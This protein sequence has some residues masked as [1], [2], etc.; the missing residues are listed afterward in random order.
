VFEEGMQAVVRV[1]DFS[2]IFDAYAKF[3]ESVVEAQMERQDASS[4]DRDAALELDLRL[5][6]LEHLMDRRPFLVNDVHLRQNPH[7]VVEWIKRV[8][9]HRNDPVK[10][11][12][13]PSLRS[14][15]SFP[16]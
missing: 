15:F 6:R 12:L 3:E 13:P 4:T 11:C 8:D 2:Q 5:A 16:F 14:A 1:R 10:A 7:N 9:L